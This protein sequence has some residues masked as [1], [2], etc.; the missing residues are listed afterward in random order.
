MMRDFLRG[1]GA[2]GQRLRIRR[3]GQTAQPALISPAQPTRSG[4]GLVPA[5]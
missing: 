5:I 2:I 1:I 4:A 3:T